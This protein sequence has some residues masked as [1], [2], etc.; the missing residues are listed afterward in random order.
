[1][2]IERHGDFIFATVDEAAADPS[3]MTNDLRA[4]GLPFTVEAVPVSPDLVG[5]W[6]G[7]ENDSGGDNDPRIVDL[8][9]QVSD[10][11]RTRQIPADFSSAVTLQVGQATPDG[12]RYLISS[13][14]A[15]DSAYACL[16]LQGMTPAEAEQSLAS[17][18]YEAR[19]YFPHDDPPTT[20]VFDSPP[21]NTIITDASF[22]GPTTVAVYV[23]D[24]GS[25]VTGRP[26][27][28]HA[29]EGC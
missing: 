12:G 21:A 27:G 22:L 14:D 29:G 4:A 3:T 13:G 20:E 2:A 6:V 23:G 9:N 10:K 25:K 5:E 7:V 11:V 18:G 16:G 1:V 28:G 15:T 19:W 8:V 26:A 17:K 24:P